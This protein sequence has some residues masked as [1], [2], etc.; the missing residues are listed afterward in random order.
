MAMNL[1]ISLR[2]KILSEYCEFRKSQ[3]QLKP[4]DVYENAYEIVIKQNIKDLICDENVTLTSEHKLAVM[5]SNNT[6]DEIYNDWLDKDGEN[7][8]DIPDTITETADRL[9]S[10]VSSKSLLIWRGFLA[11]NRLDLNTIIINMVIPLTHHR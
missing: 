3:E 5:L 1:H 7:L 8:E 10:N 6:L 4:K 2:N 9:M 11:E